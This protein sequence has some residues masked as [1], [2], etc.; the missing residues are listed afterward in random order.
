MPCVCILPDMPLSLLI[1]S[2]SSL[3]A[4]WMAFELVPAP[5]PP[6]SPSL[7]LSLSLSRR[8]PSLSLPSCRDLHARQ[9]RKSSTHVNR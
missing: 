4:S 6:L 2:S 5:L 7:C 3:L 9:T 8:S 1:P